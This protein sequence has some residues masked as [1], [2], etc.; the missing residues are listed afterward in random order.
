MRFLGWK[1]CGFRKGHRRHVDASQNRER[2]YGTEQQTEV[3]REDHRY[4]IG[5]ND[6]YEGSHTFIIECGEM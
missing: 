5:V 1:A 6:L 2:P 4:V 3:G